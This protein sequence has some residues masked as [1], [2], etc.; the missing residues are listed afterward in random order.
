MRFGDDPIEGFEDYETFIFYL[1]KLRLSLKITV[2][3]I[4]AISTQSH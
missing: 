4:G 1:D 2:F 3:P